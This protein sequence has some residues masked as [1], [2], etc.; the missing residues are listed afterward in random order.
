MIEG[1]SFLVG[2]RNDRADGRL[3]A[4]GV[5]RNHARITREE[6]VYYVEDL[7]SRNGTYVNGQLLPYKQKCQVKPGDRL[8]FAR[9]E[10]VFY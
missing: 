8:R 9:E 3:H 4:S 5:S 7:N 10:Y 6:Q 1:D 2:G